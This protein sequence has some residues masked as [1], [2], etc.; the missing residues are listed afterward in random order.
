MI[1]EKSHQVS[2]NCTSTFGAYNLDWILL[3]S[4][5]LFFN[6]SSTLSHD[7][8]WSVFSPEECFN[9]QAL[10]ISWSYSYSK[11]WIELVPERERF[12]K[13]CCFS[14]YLLNIYNLIFIWS[15]YDSQNNWLSSSSQPAFTCSNLKKET[16]ERKMRNVFKV[17]NKDTKT[18]FWCL[19]F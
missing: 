6:F 3:R 8:Q 13:S 11:F 14:R 1:L 5:S 17:N 12:I 2:K 16:V 19:Y 18:S 9:S 7:L 15:N 4:T 10:K